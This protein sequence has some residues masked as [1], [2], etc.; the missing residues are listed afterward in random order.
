MQTHLVNKELMEHT[1]TVPED[2]ILEN[3]QVEVH[4]ELL[5]WL[6]VV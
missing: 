3:W 1:S 6:L 4:V 5:S 2:V